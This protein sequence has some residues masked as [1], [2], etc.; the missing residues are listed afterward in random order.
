MDKVINFTISFPT[1]FYGVFTIGLIIFLVYIGGL[2]T[3]L[4]EV[5]ANWPKVRSALTRI[6]EILLQRELSKDFIYSESP[7][8]LSESGLAAVAEAKFKEF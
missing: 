5:C 2:H 1:W 4:K 3:K 6:S 7:I 8:N